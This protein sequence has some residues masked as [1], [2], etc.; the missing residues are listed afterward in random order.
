M[1]NR[2]AAGIKLERGNRKC[3][4]RRPLRLRRR[5]VDGRPRCR[6]CKVSIERC[7]RWRDLIMRVHDFTICRTRNN[8][9]IGGAVSLLETSIIVL[10]SI[11]LGEVQAWLLQKTTRVRYRAVTN[12]RLHKCGTTTAVCS[13]RNCYETICIIYRTCL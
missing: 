12:A 2:H 6:V 13:V 4:G 3:A 10:R 11:L 1:V 7:S 9:Q 5:A 8:V